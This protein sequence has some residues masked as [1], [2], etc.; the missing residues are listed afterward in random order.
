MHSKIK[1]YYSKFIKKIRGKALKNVIF[2]VESYCGS[3]SHIVDSKFGDYS[4]C[5]YDCEILSCT[6]GKYCSIASE[7]TIGQA[8]HNM[9]YV[10]TSPVFIKEKSVISKKF[11]KLDASQISETWIGNDV[12]IGKNAMIKSGIKVG[13]GAVVGMGAIV[14]KD[15]PDYAV[16]VGNPAQVIRFRFNEETINK[17]LEIK[18]WDKDEELLEGTGE[19]MKSPVD[20]INYIGGMYDE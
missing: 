14:T 18:W 19:Y 8:S 6:I 11:A 2:G 3:G 15:V 7:V 12:W 17:L 1:Y 9:D 16:V 13:N 20:L 5:G 4:Y 10:S